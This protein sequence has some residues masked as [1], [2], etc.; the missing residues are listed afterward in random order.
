MHLIVKIY[1][2][3]KSSCLFVKSCKK[4]NT[5]DLSSAH[6]SLSL[7]EWLQEARSILFFSLDLGCFE[8]IYTQIFMAD[9]TVVPNYSFSPCS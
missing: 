6:H 3:L 5:D 8:H 4:Q 1:L 9:C 2:T 7:S